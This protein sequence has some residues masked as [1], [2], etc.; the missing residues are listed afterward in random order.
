MN[1]FKFL[2][3][4]ELMKRISREEFC[5]NLDE[6][7]ETVNKDNTGFIITADGN[8]VRVVYKRESVILHTTT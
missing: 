5:N 8:R 1:T 4:T 3:P 2:Q 6:L 7:L